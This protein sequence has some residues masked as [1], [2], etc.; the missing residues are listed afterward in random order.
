MIPYLAQHGYSAAIAGAAVGWIGA[1]Q[2]PGR[3]LFVPIAMWLGPRGV[4]AAIFVAQA[5]GMT[6]LAVVGWLAGLA[7]V[8]VLLG[9]ANGMATLARASTVSEIFGR[10][11]YGSISGAIA[12]GANAARALAPIGASV[13]YLALGGYERLFLLLGGGLL[14]A[15]LAVLATKARATTD[16]AGT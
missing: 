11:H 9:A 3:L 8:I 2:L 7:P 15:G 13:L 12:L 14:V 16:V 6:L 1:M 10:C 4:A 5:A